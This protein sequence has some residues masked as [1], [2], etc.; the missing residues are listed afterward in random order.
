MSATARAIA[1]EVATGAA[2]AETV[3]AAALERIAAYDEV[4]PQ[5][6][7]ERVPAARVLELAIGTVELEAGAQVKGFVAEPRALERA[8]DI[9]GFG[10]WRA[11]LKGG[12]SR[13]VI[14]NQ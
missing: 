2:R 7:I 14:E 10:G 8:A 3:L 4:Q 13:D 6:W 9:T 12:A 1:A 11:F 5:V